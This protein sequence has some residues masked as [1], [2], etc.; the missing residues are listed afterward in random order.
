[1]KVKSKPLARSAIRER[2]E[3]KLRARGAVMFHGVASLFGAAV[4]LW[5]LPG[6]WENR[7]VNWNMGFRDAI[8]MLG[9]LLVSF[10]LHLIHYYFKH[11][12]GF[13][14]HEAEIETRI[15]REL[16]RADPE[17]AEERE[18]LIEL[19]QNDK[20]KNRRL[21]WQH[22]SLF[23]GLS[24]TMTLMH[25]TQVIR[26]SWNDEYAY[27]GLAY[28]IGAWAIALTAHA[29]RYYF[30]YGATSEKR[31]ARIDAEVAREMAEL[32]LRRESA[33]TG[34]RLASE[35][36]ASAVSNAYRADEF[37]GGQSRSRA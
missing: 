1:M 14:K 29:L 35:N 17:D 10:T 11:G 12:A 24:A 31:Q 3:K 2:V 36:D 32:G 19:E 22:A 5:N 26:F 34:H 23:L 16:R 25:W 15:N 28:F 4:F 9:V 20:L 37:E 13:E 33:L 8:L 6:Y 27:L 30:A 7:F 18:A 21:L